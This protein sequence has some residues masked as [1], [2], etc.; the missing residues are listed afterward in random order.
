MVYYSPDYAVTQVGIESR[1]MK[2]NLDNLKKIQNASFTTS[3]EGNN[4]EM[5]KWLK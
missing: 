2:M 4:T 1:K 5:E 3:G